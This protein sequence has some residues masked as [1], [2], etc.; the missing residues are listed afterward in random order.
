[1]LMLG[2]AAKDIFFLLLLIFRVYFQNSCV[3]FEL[4][5]GGVYFFVDLGGQPALNFSFCLRWLQG[6]ALRILGSLVFRH[7]CLVEK[8]EILE[9]FVVLQTLF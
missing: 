3:L 6:V 1:M 9:R 4:F 8:V 5:F 7:I 2:S